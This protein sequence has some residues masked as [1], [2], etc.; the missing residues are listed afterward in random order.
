MET[1][2]EI[3]MPPIE[4]ELVIE[5]YLEAGKPYRLLLTETKNYFDELDI[6]IPIDNEYWAKLFRNDSYDSFSEIFIQNEMMTTMV[7]LK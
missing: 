5:C 1:V 3:E 7:N 2:I 4:K 6:S